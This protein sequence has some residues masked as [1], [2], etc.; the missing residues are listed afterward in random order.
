MVT[1]ASNE[2]CH[3]ISKNAMEKIGKRKTYNTLEISEEN[4]LCTNG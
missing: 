2:Q 3:D 1:G 4:M